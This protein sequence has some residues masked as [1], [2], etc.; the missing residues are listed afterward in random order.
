[1]RLEPIR[2]LFLAI[3]ATCTKGGVGGQLRLKSLLSLLRFQVCLYVLARI[4][5][6]VSNVGVGVVAGIGWF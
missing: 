1:M 2:V 3:G 5:D 4:D 6:R